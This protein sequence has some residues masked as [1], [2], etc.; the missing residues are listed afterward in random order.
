M[1]PVTITVFLDRDTIKEL[2]AMH[3]LQQIMNSVYFNEPL[4]KEESTRIAEWFY[5]KYANKEFL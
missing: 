3:A 5:H 1:N 4:T 2:Q